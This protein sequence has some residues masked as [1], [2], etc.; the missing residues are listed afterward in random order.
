[1]RGLLNV[2]VQEV[3]GTFVDEMD[4]AVRSSIRDSFR[5]NSYPAA[6]M[7]SV[8]APRLLEGKFDGIS[9]A[10]KV[11]SGNRKGKA[12]VRVGKITTVARPKPINPEL[13]VIDAE[14]EDL[15]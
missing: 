6:D 3:I 12:R 11:K 9:D 5:P 8:M 1:M 15:C 4:K 10:R 7:G 14:W 13:P 2:L